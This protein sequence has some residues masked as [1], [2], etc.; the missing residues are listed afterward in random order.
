MFF[1]LKIKVNEDKP[2]IFP[3]FHTFVEPKYGRIIMWRGKDILMKHCPGVCG[4]NV[5][6]Y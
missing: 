3:K 1:F 6:K 5:C 2:I 4:S